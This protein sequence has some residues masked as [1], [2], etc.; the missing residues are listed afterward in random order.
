[1]T[2]GA[3]QA[4]TPSKE[5]TFTIQLFSSTKPDPSGFGEGETFMGEIEV[6]TNIKGAR[7]FTFQPDQPV[8]DGTFVTATAT[9]ASGNTSEFSQAKRVE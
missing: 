1:M 4:A 9:D 7:S 8:S 6:R 3:T 2:W 5:V